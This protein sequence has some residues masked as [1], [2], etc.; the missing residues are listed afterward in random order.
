MKGDNHSPQVGKASDPNTNIKITI[1]NVTKHYITPEGGRLDVLNGISFK[2]YTGEFLCVV[3]P[4]G[5]GKTTLLKIVAGLE[6]PSS[7]RVLIEGR[8]PDPSKLRIGFIFQEESLFPWRTLW[9]NIRFGLEIR[10]V[11]DDVQK[12][13]RRLIDLV[14]LKGFERYYPHQLS[15]GMRQRVAIARALAIDPEILLMD[16]PFA[17]LDAQTR[18]ILHK[19]LIRIWETV[20]KTVLFVTHNVEEAVYLSDRVIVLSA[21]PATVRTEIRVNVPRPRDRYDPKLFLLR[22]K[23]ADI[24]KEEVPTLS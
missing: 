9:D 13:V 12:T 2:V 1:D 15:G 4:S 14:G 5:C 11:G 22:R 8:P 24:L 18:G 17:N 21:R 10:K 23:I 16:E 20:K 3:G 19:D 6:P 7:G